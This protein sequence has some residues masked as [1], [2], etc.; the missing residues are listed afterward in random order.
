[1][2]R[3]IEV[4]LVIIIITAAFIISSFFAVL[5]Q[6][7][8]VSP[9][10]LRRL[11]LTTLQTLDRDYDLSEIV[12]KPPNDPSWSELQIA[13][14]ATLPPS[15]VYNLTVYEVSSDGAILYSPLKSISNAE[16]LGI[17]SEASSYLV[18][19]SNVTFNVVPEKIG[20]Q[21]GGGTL[22]IL[23]C[24]DANG[25][26]ITG[27]TAQSLAQDLYNLLSPYFQITIM[28][29]NTAQLAQVLNG[30]ALQNEVLQNAVIINTFGEAVPIPAGYYASSGVGYDPAHSSYAKY[31]HTLGLRVRQYNW[32]W[33]SIVG[34]PLYYVSNTALFPDEQNTWGIYGMRHV[35][36]AGLTAFLQGIDNQNYVYNSGWITGSPGVVYLSNEASYYCNYYGIYPSPYQT[37]TRALP[38]SILN[39]YHLTVTSYIFNQ[40][41]NWIAGAFFKNNVSGS[42]L[43]LGLTRTPDI[44][45]T[46]LG[47]LCGYKPR[48]YRSEYTAY[49]TSRLVVLQLGLVGGV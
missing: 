29:Q 10:N 31:C 19:S 41:D 34:Y 11:A 2:M 40:V 17:D 13:L 32:T 4:L 44:R 21:G 1:M 8:E 47:L 46:A 28:I 7:R 35:G 42:F 26:W 48:L 15:I 45:L 27:Y 5:P 36:P 30:T 3:T 24:S 9:L 22:Y 12:F 49:G 20:E 16:S 14:A 37:A 6:P 25:W 33:V 38:S 39:T 23:N 18:A 43:A